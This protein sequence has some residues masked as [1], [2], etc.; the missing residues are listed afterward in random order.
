MSYWLKA[1]KQNS[2][3]AREKSKRILVYDINHNYLGK[4][5]SPSDLHEWSLS[6]ENNYP[7]ILSGKAKNK[8][9]LAQNLVKSCK[10]G[11]PYKGLYFEY[12]EDARFKCELKNEEGK[13]EEPCDGN[14]ELTYSI[15]KGE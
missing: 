7:L 13:I 12:E 15:A 9:L 8:E 11:K 14:I 10:S 5:R 6:E 4:W 1:R 2:I 3:K